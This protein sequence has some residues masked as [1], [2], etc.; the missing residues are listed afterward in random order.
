LWDQNAALLTKT[1]SMQIA[2]GQR[3]GMKRLEPERDWQTLLSLLPTNFEELALEHKLL[4]VQWANAKITTAAVLLRFIFLHVGAD[5]PLRQTVALIAESGGPHLSAVR[6]HYRMRRAQP[7]LAA[8]VARMVPVAAGAPEQWGGYEMVC[9][10]ATAVSGPGA[11]GTDARLHAVIRLHDL[12][13]V[14]AEVT[15]GTGGETLKRFFW[16]PGQLVIADRGYANA[17][18]LAWVVDHD[19][20][21]LVR[22]NRGSLPLQREDGTPIDVLAWCRSLVGHAAAQVNAQA[23]AHEGR[24]RRVIHGRLVG[25]RLPDDEA[26]QAR[27]RVRREYGADASDEQLEAAS[28]VA[29]FTTAPVGR[30]SAPRCVE[31]YR[32]RWQIEL[33]FKRWKSLCHFDRLPNYRDDTI[34]SWLTAKL[35]LGVLLD[36]IGA[37]PLPVPPATGRSSRAV[38]REPWKLTSIVWPMMIAAIMPMRL[39]AVLEHLPAIVDRLEAFDDADERQVAVFRNRFYPNSRG[40]L[41]QDC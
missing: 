21:V 35:L 31:A 8:L 30:L 15:G 13:V 7:Y 16:T 20:D 23:I 36:R 2:L 11:D 39:H 3:E 38:A 12:G 6:L 17:P 19:A 9:V 27:Q 34:Q 33:Q 25:F 4:N 40:S 24:A 41:G 10:D 1:L 22:V 28:Y 14:G 29:L 5:M 18:G 37:S 32:L 26:E